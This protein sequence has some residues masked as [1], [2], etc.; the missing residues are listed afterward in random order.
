MRRRIYL[1]L[2]LFLLFLVAVG[3]WFYNSRSW[4]DAAQN[5]NFLP[6]RDQLFELKLVR[7]Q[8]TL[9]L[10]REHT[11]W[12]EKRTQRLA[13]ENSI[14]T[15]LDY[16]QR[17]EVRFP[18]SGDVTDMVRNLQDSGLQVTLCTPETTQNFVL[19]C[20]TAG[21]LILAYNKS[22]YLVRTAGF[23]RSTIYDLALSV[24]AWTERSLTIHRPSDLQTIWL[25]WPND[26]RNSFCVQVHDSLH[27]TLFDLK[28]QHEFV[29]DTVRMSAFLY[30]L[31]T[32][33]LDGNADTIRPTTQNLLHNLVP[34]LSLRLLLRG[35]KDTLAYKLFRGQTLY[36]NVKREIGY[37][38]VND[39]A[40]RTTPLVSWDAVLTTLDEIKK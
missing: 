12:Y 35:E 14:Q 5:V 36:P 15:L 18:I 26:A 9:N 11:R 21:E 19:G 4:G 25:T 28:Q 3:L 27:V 17:I 40:I 2:A 23:A 32:L 6:P 31:T 34:M 39:T 8:D 29:Y 13:T 7:G 30:A 24:D 16:F 38:F 10:V 37:L 1:Y 22:Y 20:N 33:E